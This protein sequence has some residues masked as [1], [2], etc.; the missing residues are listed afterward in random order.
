MYDKLL[1][2]KLFKAMLD[3]EVDIYGDAD[4]DLT[5]EPKLLWNAP[6]RV[7]RF[8]DC[9]GNRVI[10]NPLEGSVSAVL[11]SGWD[12]LL[13]LPDN[14]KNYSIQ[15]PNSVNITPTEIDYIF[16]WKQAAEITVLDVNDLPYR[17]A[18]RPHKMKSMHLLWC[19]QISLNPSTFD[20]LS[21]ATYFRHLP[22]L[23]LIRIVHTND[24]HHYHIERFVEHQDGLGNW[25]SK[26][27]N[28]FIEYMKFDR[29]L[30]S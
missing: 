12:L 13:G 29:S 30:D 9:R 14:Y 15:I 4:P 25:R 3:T 23:E 21:L 27:G 6:C 5:A 26:I 7:V 28:N 22:A 8:T 19:L 11:R 24:L 18:L 17:L 2:G 10:M 1:S 16:E 20:S